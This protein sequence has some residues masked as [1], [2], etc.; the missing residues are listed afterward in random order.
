MQ[1]NEF[2]HHFGL[3]AFGLILLVMTVTLRVWGKDHALS[4]SGH[5]A[6]QRPSYMIFLSGLIAAGVLFY[7]FGSRWLAPTLGLNAAFSVFL[8]AAT[9]LELV[10]AIVPDAGG[11]KSTIHRFAAWSMA[12]SMGVLG[13]LIAA[14]PGI[15]GLAQI[16]CTVLVTY[17]GFTIF[18]FLFV[19]K[20]RAHFLVYQ[21]SYVL[22]FFVVMLVAA[23]G[24]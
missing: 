3:V 8:A 1:P 20:T 11:V 18:L 23:Y 16:I 17:M 12:V 22:C 15:S 9:I 4:L 5:A 6:K 2:F 14:A 10:T 7:L 24:R 13:I 21:S 19:P